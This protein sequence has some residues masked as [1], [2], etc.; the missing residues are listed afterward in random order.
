MST[1]ILILRETVWKDFN[2]D[3]FATKDNL[4]IL[5]FESVNELPQTFSQDI[6]SAILVLVQKINRLMILRGA[7]ARQREFLLLS[8]SPTPT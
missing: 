2:I 7:T 3:F 6:Y 5:N 1:K 4:D 8:G